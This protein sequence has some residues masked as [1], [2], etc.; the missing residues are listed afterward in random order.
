MSQSTIYFSD[1]FFS[2]GVTTIFNEAKEEVGSLDLKSAFTSS[3]E[4]L[5]EAGVVV[6]KGHF[7]IF[8]RRWQVSDGNDNEVGLLKQRISF[9]TKKYEYDARN[10][11]IY[12]IVSEAFSKEFQIEN[13]DGTLVA[14]FKRISGFFQSPAFQLQNGSE[15]LSNEELIAVVMGV[16][17]II[18]RN[19]AAASNNAGR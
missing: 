17:M 16:N 3:I 4:V 11:G 12:T 8:S 1:N 10:R 7:P 19:R 5:N 18:K 14:E 2:T 6:M 9:F 13:S 15:N